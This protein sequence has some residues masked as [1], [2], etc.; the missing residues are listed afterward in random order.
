MIDLKN[1]LLVTIGSAVGG[2]LRFVLSS[3]IQTKIVSK[4]P[5]GTFTIN[6]LGCL[7]IGIILGYAGKSSSNTASLSLLLATGFCGGFTTFSAFGFENVQL[8]KSG[9]NVTALVYIILSVTLG[10]LAVKVGLTIVK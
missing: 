8:L 2:S 3:F 10:I 5:L 6:T 4:F 9:F 1:I 7:L